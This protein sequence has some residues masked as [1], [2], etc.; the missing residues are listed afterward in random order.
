MKRPKKSRVSKKPVV[1]SASQAVYEPRRK[2]ESRNYGETANLTTLVGI[3]VS[4]NPESTETGSS[5]NRLWRNLDQDTDNACDYTDRAATSQVQVGKY[6]RNRLR[7]ELH[8]W[9][10]YMYNVRSS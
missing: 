4:P 6:A 9:F 3:A 5:S 10:T 2:P 8:V 1:K 7:T